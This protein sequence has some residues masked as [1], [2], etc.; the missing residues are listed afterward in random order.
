MFAL[1]SRERWPAFQARF[2]VC[3]DVS[4]TLSAVVTQ[5]KLAPGK[6]VAESR[7]T[8][9]LSPPTAGC[10]RYR[11]DWLVAKGMAHDG[12]L[13][14]ELRVRD[15]RGRWSNAVLKTYRLKK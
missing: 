9:A 15:G 5:R 4:T 6:P 7:F 3:D 10:S 11:L 1:V 8:R 2:R 14:V 12:T 13:A